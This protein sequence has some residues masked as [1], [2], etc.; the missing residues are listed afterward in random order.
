MRRNIVFLL[1]ACGTSRIVAQIPRVFPAGDLPA[2]ARLSELR[3]LNS[4]F[5]FTAVRNEEQWQQRQ[6]EIKRRIL[7]SQGLW[8]EPTKTNLQAAVHGRVEH[9]DYTVECVYFQSIPG[10]YVTGSL[11]RPKG[12]QGPFPAVLCPHGHWRNARFYDAGDTAARRSVASGAER[13]LNAARNHIQARCVQL[14]RMGCIAL[15]YDMTGN[16]DSIQIGHRPERS[17]HLDTPEHWGFLS[18][19][20]ELRLQNMMGLQ[21]WNSVRAIDFL[22]E[23]SDVDTKRIGVTGA[24][25][26]GTQSMIIAAIDDRVTAAMPCVMVSTAMQGGC[27]CENAPLMRI[28]QGNIDIAAAVAPRPLGL[29]AADDWTKE[30]ET[31]GYPALQNLYA[32]LGYED[33][34]TAVFHTH[35]PHNYNHV[36]RTV[37]YSFFNR[38]FKLGLNEPVLESD[39]ELLSKEQLSVW[40]DQHLAPSGSDVG[41][42]HEISLLGLATEDSDEQLASVVPRSGQSPERFQ[43]V[44]GAAWATILDRRL[45]QVGEIEFSHTKEVADGEFA[46][47]LGQLNHAA[48]SEQLPAMKLRG[49][50]KSQ[51]GV[52]IWLTE[53]GK[54]DLI[55][56]GKVIMPVAKLLEKGYTVLSADL[57]GQGEFL[58]SDVPL[59]AQ[60]M[61][62]QQ[63]GNSGWKRFAGYT[64][65]YNHSMFVKRTHDVLSLIKYATTLSRQQ[66]IHLV[67]LDRTAGPIALAARSQ[68]ADAVNTTIVDLA[69]FQFRG[70]TS[71]D[72]PMFVS[73]AVK[74][75]DVTGLLSLCAPYDISIA[76]LQKKSVATRVFAATNA[77][78]KLHLVDSRALMLAL[79]Q[80]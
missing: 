35:F 24:S 62:Y 20:A 79:E 22:S 23:L 43:N 10:H 13:F 12:K 5:P 63:D 68:A 60:R 28:G 64:Y 32:M 14:A 45:D 58:A 71:H 75:L 44:V 3:T 30:L 78:A 74:Y 76:G 65:G 61:W 21:T 52:V 18:V 50:S 55:K 17:D 31:K 77:S 66:N 67:G 80:L 59:E 36:N 4:Y 37:M 39:F 51:K 69:G 1:L 53:T 48:M 9:D 42:A 73:G 70:I 34:L 2:D 29:T 8:P 47:T 15:F 26:G 57:S 49:K 41:D 54:S 16:C 7:I 38:H 25:G 19:Q 72:D 46:L 27:T 40:N 6:M 33:R 11:Y 56:D